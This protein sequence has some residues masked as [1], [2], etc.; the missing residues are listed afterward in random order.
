MSVKFKVKFR[1]KFK[2]KFR[3]RV[4]INKSVIYLILI[5]VTIYTMPRTVSVSFAK[6]VMGQH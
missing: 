5:S 6:R 1:V 4:K 2:V 3:V